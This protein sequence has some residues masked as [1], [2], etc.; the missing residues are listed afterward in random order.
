MQLT[1]TL[2]HVT[3]SPYIPAFSLSWLASILLKVFLLHFP[4]TLES[5]RSMFS[6]H[7][8]FML[9]TNSNSNSISIVQL[10]FQ[11]TSSLSRPPSSPALRMQIHSPL[12][13]E[14]KCKCM[15]TRSSIPHWSTLSSILLPSQSQSHASSVSLLFHPPIRPYVLCHAPPPLRP[16][17]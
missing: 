9:H 10:A 8:A 17:P 15:Y 6:A 12:S 14:C 5:V 16:A 11:H 1:W 7:S 3:S 2:I 4:L 13:I